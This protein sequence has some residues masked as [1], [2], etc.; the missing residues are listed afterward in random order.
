MAKWKVRKWPKCKVTH[1]WE[2]FDPEG[3]FSG[4]FESWA[5]AMQWATSVAD[6]LEWWLNHQVSQ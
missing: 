1:V 5:E 2:V 3:E 6:R 4:A